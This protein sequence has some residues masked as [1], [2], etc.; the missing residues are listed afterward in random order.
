MDWNGQKIY[1]IVGGSRKRY[2]GG[3]PDRVEGRL[4]HGTNGESLASRFNY[5]KIQ[6]HLVQ[7]IP[8]HVDSKSPS[9]YVV[10]LK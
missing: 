2:I 5:D 1:S 3:S 10:G 8:V 6:E 4:Y 9:I 7:E